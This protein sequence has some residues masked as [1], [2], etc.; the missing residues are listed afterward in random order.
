MAYDYAALKSLA[1]SVG[2]SG[3]DLDVAAA[4]A[5]AESGGRPEAIS[6]TNDY[7][8]WQINAPSWPQFT[9]TELLT[10]AGNARAMA[11]VRRSGRGWNHWT[12]YR[13]G[14]YRRH[15]AAGAAAPTGPGD[16]VDAL[17]GP[18]PSDVLDNLNP[19]GWV[20]DLLGGLGS[21]LLTLLL[22]AAGAALVHVGVV[23]LTLKSE[24]GKT[25][26]SLA[27]GASGAGAAAAML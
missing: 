4:I 2:L 1:A 11:T 21:L 14:A 26:A 24:T 18:N 25:V 13:T 3:A 19:A 17:P 15:M 22:T 7:G 9:K 8:L 12:T 20:D 16:I 5:L 23:R 10:P 27:A 6:R